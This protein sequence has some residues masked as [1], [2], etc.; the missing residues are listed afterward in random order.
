MTVSL[1]SVVGM[2]RNI[3]I[4]GVK[5]F[6]F[7]R[8]NVLLSDTFSFNQYAL[9]FMD[10][11][12]LILW[13]TVIKFVISYAEN[14]NVETIKINNPTNLK[15]YIFKNKGCISS[16]SATTNINVTTLSSESF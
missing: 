7:S 10:H 5:L 1:P 13:A 6:E 2:D 14:F 9:Y 15:K 4:K 12:D 3:H 8:I 16:K 11:I